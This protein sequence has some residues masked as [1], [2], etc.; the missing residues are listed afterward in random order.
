MSRTHSWGIGNRPLPARPDPAT[1]LPRPPAGP[2]WSLAG[3]LPHG[4]LHPGGDDPKAADGLRP[5]PPGCGRVLEVHRGT[6]W[7]GWV[8]VGMM[9]ALVGL[10]A[11]VDSRVLGFWWLWVL[12]AVVTVLGAR[13]VSGTYLAAGADFLQNRRTWVDLYDLTEITVAAGNGQ[14]WI[15]LDDGHGRRTSAGTNDLHAS[16]ALWDL[17]YNGIRHSVA[18]GAEVKGSGARYLRPPAAGD[19]ADRSAG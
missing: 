15:T 13:S 12:V 1:G 16:P 8:Y 14:H 6:R 18:A 11:L 19:G 5:P 4:N 7:D 17:V 9:A 2:R 10:G 3:P